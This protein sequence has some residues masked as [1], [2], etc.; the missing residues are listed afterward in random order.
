MLINN[1]EM[2][3]ITLN[4]LNNKLN[5]FINIRS[6]KNQ[7]NP[8]IYIEDEKNE[9]Y[10]Y[11]KDNY[12]EIDLIRWFENCT[13]LDSAKKRMINKGYSEDDICCIEKVLS[14][15]GL[16]FVINLNERSD[17]DYRGF[18][19]ILQLNHISNIKKTK[20]PT[21]IELD[22][23]STKLIKSLLAELFLNGEDFK[24]FYVKSGELYFKTDNI[25]DMLFLDAIRNIHQNDSNL[26]VYSQ[27]RNFHLAMVEILTPKELNVNFLLDNCDLNDYNLP[28]AYCENFLTELYANNLRILSAIKDIINPL[29]SS[30]ELFVSNMILMNFIF[31]CLLDEPDNIL[32]LREY[33]NDENDFNKI[34]QAIISRKLIIKKSDFV[35]IID[36]DS[37]DR[38]LQNECTIFF[39][40]LYE[41]N[42]K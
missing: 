4:L 8:F 14:R 23:L 31:F 17:K 16:F 5:N 27:L 1:E 42:R 38:I 2:T 19:F 40:I 35:G 25:G 30:A 21:K 22:Y 7:L 11:L 34:L 18:F 32:I 12:E 26:N 6:F 15:F 33:L 37:L 41:I 24:R 13:Y 3:K 29:Q 9:F 28:L 20:L 36:S 39:N 10:L